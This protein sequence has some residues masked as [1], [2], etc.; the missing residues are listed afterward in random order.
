VK[1][2]TG[3]SREEFKMNEKLKT[4]ISAILLCSAGNRKTVGGYGKD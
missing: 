1:E 4:I 2:K 3:G